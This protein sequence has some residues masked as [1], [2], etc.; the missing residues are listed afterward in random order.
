MKIFAGMAAAV[1]T[2]FAT[3]QL[4]AFDA[5]AAEAGETTRTAQALFQEGVHYER[6]PTTQPTSSPAGTIEVTEFFMYTC[7]HCFNF[8]PHVSKWLES[9]PANVNFVRVPASF[10]RLAL[11]H[12]QAFYAAESLGVLEDVH[13]DFFR[14]FHVKRNR[15]NSPKAV[16]DFF[17]A[18]GV[19][20]EEFKA[21][22]SSFPVDAKLKR[23]GTLAQRYRVSSVP[24][25]YVNGKYRT[26]AS[27]AGDYP[28]LL[29]VIDYLVSLESAERSAAT[30]P[31]S[32]N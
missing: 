21:A 26:D 27:M 7:P 10:N 20:R 1:L 22:M 19:D 9:K 31:T 8:E 24:S 14:E 18:H 17:V 3:F 5:H 15:M 30:G 28:Q 6:L 2:A 11:L 16:E 13:E 12:A 4:G 29:R 25:V 23:S 32:G